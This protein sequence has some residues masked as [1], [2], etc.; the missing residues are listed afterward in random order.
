MVGKARRKICQLK[1]SNWKIYRIHSEL[2]CDE[3]EE[4]IIETID[5]HVQDI[6][7]QNIHVQ[8]SLSN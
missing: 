1:N 4:Y 2:M 5:I 6:H 7:V 3:P 8:N